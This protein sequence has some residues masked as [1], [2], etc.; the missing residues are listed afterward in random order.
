VPL[1]MVL[2][3]RSEEFEARASILFDETAASHL[4]LDALLAAVNLTV[5]ALIK[6]ATE[7]G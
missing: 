6:T 2:W 1:T 5:D 4:P 3:R 7:S